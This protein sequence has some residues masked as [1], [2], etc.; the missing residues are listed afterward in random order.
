MNEVA[1]RDLNDA[2]TRDRLDDHGRAVGL[3]RHARVTRR[4]RRIGHIVEAVEET[5]KIKVPTAVRRCIGR[6]EMC[7][8]G[9]RVLCPLPRRFDGL[10]MIVVADEFGIRIRLCHQ[11]RARA[12][13]AAY[14]GD[15]AATP[16][17]FG[18]TIERRKPACQ[19]VG[20]VAG[21]EE[22]LRTVEQALVV[23]APFHPLAGAEI[24]D[25]AFAYMEEVTHNEIGARQVH[26]TVG[27]GEDQRLLLFQMVF[28]GLRIVHDIAAGRLVA[29]PL[30]GIAFV[31]T[32]VAR[33]LGGRHRLFGERLVIAEF[34]ADGHQH[35]AHRRAEITD[36]PVE[37][38]VQFVFVNGHGS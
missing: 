20:V 2:I 7:I 16:E 17:L 37:K 24:L 19:Q 34:V 38:F 23:L 36:R 9:V 4:A 35:G 3:Q 5:D 15:A 1:I 11:D 21:A 18:D 31:G 32:G 27:I 8:G 26:G 13:A 33:K 10:R 25:R 29:E 6:F 30:A 12:V 22:P 14:V 28:A